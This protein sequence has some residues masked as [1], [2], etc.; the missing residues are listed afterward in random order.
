MNL[1]HDPETCPIC[2]SIRDFERLA[3]P[4]TSCYWGAPGCNCWREA[5]ASLGLDYSVLTLDLTD[6]FEVESLGD[7][8]ESEL[9][10]VIGDVR[11]GLFLTPG[12]GDTLVQALVEEQ[13]DH[14]ETLADLYEAQERVEELEAELAAKDAALA[15][16]IRTLDLAARVLER[17][18]QQARATILAGNL[19]T[20]LYI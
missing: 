8:A 5:E 2:Q 1:I 19:F 7:E 9:T 12:E 17:Q 10:R 15:L 16:A 14:G 11:A 20:S 13:L 18:N 6:L 4:S 3:A